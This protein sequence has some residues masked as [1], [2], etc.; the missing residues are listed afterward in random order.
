M[1]ISHNDKD[2]QRCQISLNGRIIWRGNILEASEEENKVWIFDYTKR[3]GYHVEYGTVK[4][5]L[6]DIVDAT[7]LRSY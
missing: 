5:H 1:R 2:F 7:E 3:D 4:I 6:M